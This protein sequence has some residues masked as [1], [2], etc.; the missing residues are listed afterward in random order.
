MDSI[1]ESTRTV[2][3]RYVD[4]DYASDVESL[5]GYGDWNYSPTYS[6]YVWSPHVD[7]NWMPFSVGS[8]YYTPA[9]LTWW[10]QDPWGWYPHHYGN[11]YFEASWNRWCWSPAAVYS[12]AWVYWAYSGNYVGWCPTGWYSGYGPWQN[13]RNHRAG[14]SYLALHG[15]F[16][17]REVDFRGWNFTGAKGFGAGY[18]RAEVVRG[19]RIASQLGAVVSI[20]S[21]PIVV[22]AKPGEAREAIRDYVREAPRVI[23]RASTSDPSRLTPI[24]GRQKT[25]PPASVEALREGTVTA[26][27]GRLA[28]PAAAELAPRGAR[29]ERGRAAIVESTPRGASPDGKAGAIERARP[30]EGGLGSTGSPVFSSRADRERGRMDGPAVPSVSSSSRERSIER[31]AP[32]DR[33][34]ESWRSRGRAPE[35]SATGSTTGTAA[36]TTNSSVS[37]GGATRGLE[38]G[39]GEP[40]ATDSRGRRQDWRTKE[41][42]PARR[43]IDGSVPG[44]REIRSPEPRAPETRSP[45]PRYRAS[46]TKPETKSLEAPRHEAPPARVEAPPPAPR[47]SEVAHPESRPAPPAPRVE[48]H[49]APQAP[50]SHSDRNRKD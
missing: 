21:K 19:D 23:E 35:T 7:I 33:A 5:D 34:A 32:A 41:V 13:Y 2:S 30:V 25:L 4:E 8:W 20:S 48:S 12:P 39:E 26:E 45:E 47:H 10:S 16:H 18:G 28:G 37:T 9:G 40:S 36:Q 49:P 38:R 11:W 24:L 3:A 42:P 6:S 31:A 46:D 50:D 17:P 15:T 1:A 29:I 44:R 14:G 43:V 27:R 22:S